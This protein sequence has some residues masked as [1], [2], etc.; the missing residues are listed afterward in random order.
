[1]FQPMQCDADH[2]RTARAADC[3]RRASPPMT[4]DPVRTIP[5][6]SDPDP[7]RNN[8]RRCI[9][10]RRCKGDDRRS[11]PDG[12]ARSPT[13]AV[14][15][16]VPSG[17]PTPSGMVP[18]RR[19]RRW[20]QRGHRERSDCGRANRQSHTGKHFLHDHDSYQIQQCAGRTPPGPR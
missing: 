20:H 13:A 3:R 16:I 11:N 10:D 15:T 8:E 7:A 18:P 4:G 17:V 19:C 5:V 1:M 12:D 6:R 9:D 14:P 2:V